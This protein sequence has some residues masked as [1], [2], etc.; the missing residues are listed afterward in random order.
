MEDEDQRMDDT[1]RRFAP[2]WGSLTRVAAAKLHGSGTR[3]PSA[4]PIGLKTLPCL[5]L[6]D[7]TVV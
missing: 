6:S 2:K 1:E 3:R 7:G 4:A 5:P